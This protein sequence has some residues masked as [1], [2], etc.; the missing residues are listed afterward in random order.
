MGI[1]DG[2]C[3]VLVGVT[4]CEGREFLLEGIHVVNVEEGAFFDLEERVEVGVDLALAG[5]ALLGEGE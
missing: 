5:V 4:E 1:G 2:E 3:T